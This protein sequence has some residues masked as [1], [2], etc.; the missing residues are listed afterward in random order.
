[1]TN[2]LHAAQKAQDEATIDFIINRIGVHEK[3]AWILRS[4]LL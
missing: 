4:S 1:L 3:A 2:A